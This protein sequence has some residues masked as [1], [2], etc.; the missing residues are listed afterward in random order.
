M[1][2]YLKHSPCD[3]RREGWIQNGGR[4]FAYRMRDEKAIDMGTL[5][6]GFELSFANC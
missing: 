2:G 4:V 5:K 3:G 6:F 1:G